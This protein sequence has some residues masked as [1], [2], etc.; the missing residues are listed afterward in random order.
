M[1][2]LRKLRVFCW[3]LLPQALQQNQGK[4]ESACLLH[5]K[6]QT[7]IIFILKI[8]NKK[9]CL[10][11]SQSFPVH[12]KAPDP[13]LCSF[14]G[15]LQVCFKLSCVT[16]TNLFFHCSVRALL[17][18]SD[19]FTSEAITFLQ[20]SPHYANREQA[21]WQSPWS[22]EVRSTLPFRT[23][24]SLGGCWL[25]SGRQ[26]RETELPA[27][28]AWR[29]MARLPSESP[30]PLCSARSQLCQRKGCDRK[31][32]C[33]QN[34]QGSRNAARGRRSNRFYYPAATS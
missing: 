28:P 7:E 5:S 30:P 21:A 33:P 34:S 14:A 29:K 9:K 20:L 31:P 18:E 11:T 19:L 32:P 17:S 12:H 8:E 2:V 6:H 27:S 23:W 10:H 26:P 22:S 1:K 13:V 16:V 4:L 3:V 15:H 24:T 25:L